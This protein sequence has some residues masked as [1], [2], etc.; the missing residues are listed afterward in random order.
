MNF[1]A[2]THLVVELWAFLPFWMAIFSPPC[3][4]FFPCS[5]SAGNETRIALGCVLLGRAWASPTYTS[6]L[7][8][9]YFFIY[10]VRLA[11]NHLQFLFCVYQ[12]CVGHVHVLQDTLEHARILNALSTLVIRVEIVPVTVLNC[13][14]RL[15]KQAPQA[16]LRAKKRGFGV[17]ENEKGL[18]VLLKGT[19]TALVPTLS[20]VRSDHLGIYTHIHLA[21]AHPP[22]PCI[23]LVI[24]WAKFDELAVY[25]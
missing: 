14:V 20:R 7:W 11:V 4:F 21:H 1:G 3:V 18:A 24:N 9:I 22:R 10:L 17:G 19:I 5:R 8:I 12:L 15:Q 2:E 13:D 23:H 16:L 6:L 25:G